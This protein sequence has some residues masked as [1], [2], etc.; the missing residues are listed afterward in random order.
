MTNTE[1]KRSLW[2]SRE[3]NLAKA[4]MHFPELVKGI[5][6]DPDNDEKP[7]DKAIEAMNQELRD[8][9]Y[10]VAAFLNEHPEDPMKALYLV[11]VGVGSVLHSVFADSVREKMDK[12]QSEA[13]MRFD[14]EQAVKDFVNGK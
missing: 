8:F 9:I 4:V 10:R 1:K 6:G 13:M 11:E 12:K 14:S 3:K 2:L 5:T 7:K